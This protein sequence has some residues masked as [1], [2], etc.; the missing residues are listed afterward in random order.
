[1]NKNKEELKQLNSQDLIAKIATYKRELFTLK[2]NAL[3]V[4]VKDYSQFKKLRK[5][6]ARAL[7]YIRHK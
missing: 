6:V 2:L 1:M 3:T 5:N 7:T 4:H